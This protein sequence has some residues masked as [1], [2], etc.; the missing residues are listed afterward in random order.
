MRCNEPLK[1][2]VTTGLLVL[3]SVN[4]P[5]QFHQSST[6]ATISHGSLDGRDSGSIFIYLN[7]LTILAHATLINN[8]LKLDQAGHNILAVQS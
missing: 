1:T 5:F 7:N 6:V 8:F 3:R 2:L 4:L